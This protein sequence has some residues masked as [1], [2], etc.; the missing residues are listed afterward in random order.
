M[1]QMRDADWSREN[2]LRSDWL[3]PKVATIT[4]VIHGNIWLYMA[5]HGNTWLYM[6]IHGNTWLYMVIHG[7]T[8]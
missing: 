1:G 5:L 3:V 7:D 2:L 6:V 4:T 8:W